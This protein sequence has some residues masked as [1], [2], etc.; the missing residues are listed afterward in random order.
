M[1]EALERAL[2]FIERTSTYLPT[3]FDFEGLNIHA[4]IKQALAA[5]VQEPV[6]TGDTLFRQF[7]SDADKAGIT[8]WPNPPAAQ[9]QWAGLTDDELDEAETEGGKSYKRW[10]SRIRGQ[11]LMPQDGLQ[12]H[13][14]RA[15]EAKLKEKN[16]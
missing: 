3:T 1:R 12:W 15:I 10:A 14:S 5:P 13:V 9:R 2:E 4:A 6:K 16:T 11:M 7:M 8:H